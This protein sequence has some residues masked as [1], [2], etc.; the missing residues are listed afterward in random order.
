MCLSKILKW[1]L[2]YIGVW[3]SGMFFLVPREYM[4]HPVVMLGYVQLNSMM[5][6]GMIAS[7]VVPYSKQDKCP[8]LSDGYIKL[9]LVLFFI[10][11]TYVNLNFPH[12]DCFLTRLFFLN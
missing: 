4:S 5:V 12:K 10:I 3:W 6:I 7:L 9:T 8:I 11:S 2:C 1:I